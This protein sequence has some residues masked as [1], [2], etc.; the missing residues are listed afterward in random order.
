MLNLQLL[1]RSLLWSIREEAVIPAILGLTR[2]SEATADR[3][4]A[5]KPSTM[6]MGKTG[7]KMAVIPVE[8]VLTKD[9]PAWYG[10]NYDSISKALEM[11]AADSDV[12]HI[13]MSVDSPGGEVTGLPETAQLVA[14]VAKSKP[15]TAMVHGMS[16]SAAYWLT[17]QARDVVLTPSGEVGSIGVRMMHMDVSKML[18]NAGVKVTEL[19]SGDHKTEWSPYKPLSQDAIDAEMP[20]LQSAHQQFISAVSGAR[21]ERLGQQMRESRIGEGRMFSANDA[22]S[23]GLVDILQSQRDFYKSIVTESAQTDP[24]TRGFPTPAHREHAHRLRLS[25]MM[26]M[27][28][29][30]CECPECKDGRCEDCSHDACDCEGCTCNEDMNK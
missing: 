11:S 19:Y 9:G 16:A 18:D 26:P 20:R 15:V 21:G 30:V 5:A 10:S 22:L 7:N 17:S 6:G 14:E 23:H 12:K 3:W 4:E 2:P 1:T 25:G 8:G 24:V 28:D 27:S 13:V 29:C